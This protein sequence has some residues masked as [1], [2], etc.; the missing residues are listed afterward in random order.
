MVQITAS[1]RKKAFNSSFAG[2]FAKFQNS[3][4]G[5]VDRASA[6]LKLLTVD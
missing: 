6:F 1:Q 4:D 5:G 2:T 3:S